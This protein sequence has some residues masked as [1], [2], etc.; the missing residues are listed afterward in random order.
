MVSSH[1]GCEFTPAVPA[2]DKH[3][4]GGPQANDGAVQHTY[5]RECACEN[6]MHTIS[7]AAEMKE[8]H[9]HE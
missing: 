6:D 9:A 3:G 2:F 8:R 4:T 7:R 1:I 5:I